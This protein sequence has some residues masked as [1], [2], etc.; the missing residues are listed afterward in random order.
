M[1]KGK[2]KNAF[3][4]YWRQENGEKEVAGQV[5]GDESLS[6]F[7]PSF[8]L[9]SSAYLLLTIEQFWELVEDQLHGK[10][11]KVTRTKSE[12]R[13]GGKKYPLLRLFIQFFLSHLLRVECVCLLFR[14][15]AELLKGNFSHRSFQVW[16]TSHFFFLPFQSSLNGPTFQRLFYHLLT[17]SMSHYHWLT[18]YLL[19]PIKNLPNFPLP[20]SIFASP[21]RLLSSLLFLTLHFCCCF[22]ANFFRQMYQYLV[23]TLLLLLC[24]WYYLISSFFKIAIQK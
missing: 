17:V 1:V 3:F 10:E 8:A 21:S 19:L 20:L 22:L 12:G 2:V 13:G 18:D 7:L 14:D 6:S 24:K 15:Q 9:D 11:K 23:T 5:L 16:T 4:A